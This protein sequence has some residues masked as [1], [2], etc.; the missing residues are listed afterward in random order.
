ML[1]LFENAD[2]RETNQAQHNN[3]DKRAENVQSRYE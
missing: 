3:T 2:D 1:V